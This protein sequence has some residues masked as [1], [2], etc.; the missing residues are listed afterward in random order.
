MSAAKLEASLGYIVTGPQ[1]LH[2]KILF[3][4]NKQTNKQTNNSKKESW[5][6]SV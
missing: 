4:T 5:P 6:Y 3:Q 2:S 1:G